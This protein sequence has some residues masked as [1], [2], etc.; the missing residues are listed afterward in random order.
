MPAAPGSQRPPTRNA[1]EKPM[2]VQGPEVHIPYLLIK[3]YAVC[4]QI[5]QRYG[6][7]FLL[8]VVVWYN[9]REAV[10]RSLATR[11]HRRSL[12]EANRSDRVSVLDEQRQRIREKQQHDAEERA[13]QWH[14]EQEAAKRARRAPQRPAIAS[15]STSS[16]GGL[17][18]ATETRSYRPEPRRRPGASGGG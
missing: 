16:A 12:A 18:S 17:R 1:P 7:Y 6:W 8:A 4:Q 10:Y 13:E 9:V 5:L 14:R 2:I 3:V 15:H 11:A